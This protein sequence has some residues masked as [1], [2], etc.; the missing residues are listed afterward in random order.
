MSATALKSLVF[1]VLALGVLGCDDGGGGGGGKTPDMAVSAGGEGGE[2]G[3]GAGG[4]GGEGGQGG[5]GGPVEQPLARAAGRMTIE[6]L[7]RSI[8]IV[9]GGLRWTEDFGNGPT[10]MLEVLAPTLGQP[11][12]IRITSENLEP[13][14]IIAKFVQ[15][16]AYRICGRWV[17]R[18]RNAPLAERTLVRHENW[19][20]LGEVDAKANLRM[21][22]LRFYARTI[23]NDAELTD[24][25]D[26]FV[27][28]SST[29]PAGRGAQDGWT[30][31][32]IAMMTDP[33]FIL[34]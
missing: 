19:T 2:G 8:P 33:E 17:D 27:N 24:L 12:Y 4:A 10:D 14:L 15:D 1:S 6:Q 23:G 18:D 30:A 34:Y 25:Y 31:V 9:T 16:A 5:G 11:D 13:T 3:G 20:S 7:A 22:N 29:A 26:L 28:A 32:C 21:L